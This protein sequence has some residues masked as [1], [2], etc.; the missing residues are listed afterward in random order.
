M[1]AVRVFEIIEKLGSLERRGNSTLPTE[2]PVPALPPVVRSKFRT[3][4]SFVIR[5]AQE[6]SSWRGAALVLGAIG[7]TIEPEYWE[8]FAAAGMAV[9]GLIGMFTG[10]RAPAE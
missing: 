1:S 10:D 3:A 7:G 2:A 9:A 4:L 5:R 8:A 6:P